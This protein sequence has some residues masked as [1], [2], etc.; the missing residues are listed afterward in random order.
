VNSH[1]V[2]FK[3]RKLEFFSSD[4]FQRELVL[5]TGFFGRSIFCVSVLL[6]F[7]FEIAQAQQQKYKDT[8]INGTKVK[9]H[10]ET[11]AIR[12]LEAKDT[13][14]D[15]IVVQKNTIQKKETQKQSDFHKVQQNESFID[16]AYKYNISVLELK[17]ANNLDNF[18]IKPG[19]LLRVR[20]VEDSDNKI[21]TSK[22]KTSK[23]KANAKDVWI[24]KKGETLYHIATTNN[25]TVEQLKTLNGLSSNTIA[26]GQE[27]RLRK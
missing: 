17:Q 14:K 11:G 9:V 4:N 23:I 1:I 26:I 25:M 2:T 12:F 6:L 20:N 3:K 24:V 22:D 15:S 13:P 5:R 7:T 19:Q 21:S 16:I 8:I 10:I 18:N 27:L